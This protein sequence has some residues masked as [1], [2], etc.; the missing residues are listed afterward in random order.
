[1]HDAAT[2]MLNLIHNAPSAEVTWGD[3]ITGLERLQSTAPPNSDAETSRPTNRPAP[4]D[5]EPADMDN[6]ASP[7]Y[8]PL[9]RTT[10]LSF[11]TRP[12]FESSADV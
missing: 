10:T 5:T 12:V 7:R 6:A 1:M 9:R 8:A 3:V 11:A 4:Y 2:A